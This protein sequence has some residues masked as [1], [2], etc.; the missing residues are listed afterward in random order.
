MRGTMKQDELIRKMRDRAARSRR[1]AAV[2]SDEDVAASLMQLAGE[3]DA[4]VARLQKKD[5]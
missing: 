5:L 2:A 1:L 4:D 3:I